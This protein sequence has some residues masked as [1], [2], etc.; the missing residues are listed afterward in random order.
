VSLAPAGTQ[1]VIAGTTSTIGG[2]IITPA[3]SGLVKPSQ[4]VVGSGGVKVVSSE[5]MG[6]GML[7]LVVGLAVGVMMWL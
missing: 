7:S 1:V 6:K 3:T 4:V 5:L 2:A